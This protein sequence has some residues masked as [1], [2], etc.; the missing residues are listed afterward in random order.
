MKTPVVA[1]PPSELKK[2]TIGFRMT[3]EGIRLLDVLANQLGLTRSGVVE[4][5][6]RESAR[7]IASGHVRGRKAG[8]A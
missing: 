5:L 4:M 2:K 8:A 7:A 3:P 1:A 6:L